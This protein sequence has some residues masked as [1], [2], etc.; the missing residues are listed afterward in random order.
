MN[1][2]RIVLCLILIPLVSEVKG[3]GIINKSEGSITFVVDNN[4]K[5]LKTDFS[6]MNGE[7]S[8]YNPF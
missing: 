6:L 5:P 2:K 8:K 1:L 7:I 4:V 3:K